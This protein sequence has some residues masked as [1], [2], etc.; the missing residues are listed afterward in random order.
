MKKQFMNAT[1]GIAM[2]MMS[3]AGNA[4]TD[5]PTMAEIM[6]LIKS[7]QAEIEALKK[8]V[9]QTDQKVE[10]TADAVETI[11]SSTESYA[12]IASWADKT[13]IG[14]YGEMHY[15]DKKNSDNEIDS[16]RFV[17]FVEHEFTDDVRLFS[18]VE[19][20]HSIAGDDKN[21][22]VELEQA[23]IE[24]DYTD[25]HNAT[26]GQF[27]IPIGIINET[28]E[29]DTFYGVERNS[30]EKNIIP[31]TWWE[32]GVML[33]GEMAPG[34][35][36][37]VAATS[38][39]ETPTD[40]KD[41]FLPR[42]GR[43]KVSK[44]TAEDFAYTGR[45]KYTGIAGLELATTLQYQED[46]AQGKG[47]DD[48][49]ALLWE[50]HVIYQ[51]GGFGLRAL[52]AIWDIEGDE[53]EAFGRDEQE[54]LYVE[55]SYRLNSQWGFF[56]RYSEWDNNAGDN[57]DT[58]VEEWDL[59]VNFWLVENVVFKADWADQK[60]GEDSFNLGVGWSF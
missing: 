57:D 41:A 8:L 49:S 36:Y 5:E 24:W 14:G 4:S 58:K 48:A 45:L 9:R 31:A 30:V 34:F 53:A 27:L 46:I 59:G 19:L 56:V 20:E 23:Y 33:S 11:A 17:L 60:N 44:A 10:D 3:C 40:G 51:A 12:K 32:G 43:Q 55:P 6:A 13:H 37:D 50:T 16:H 2:A 29:P 28:H 25:N 52:Y 1:L 35:T 42:K 39:L 18:E 38:G 47:I 22:E 54:G 26:F 15:N 7:Q 21:G